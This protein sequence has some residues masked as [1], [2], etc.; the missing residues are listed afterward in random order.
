MLPAVGNHTELGDETEERQPAVDLG[1]PS[2]A[3]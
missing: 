3:G 1:W 2:M